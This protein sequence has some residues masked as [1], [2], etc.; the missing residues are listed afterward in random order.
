MP[1]GHGLKLET[2]ADSRHVGQMFLT[3]VSAR[4]RLSYKTKAA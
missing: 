1:A 2:D 4:Q 3:F